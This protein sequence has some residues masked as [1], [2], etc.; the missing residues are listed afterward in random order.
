[1]NLCSLD[2]LLGKKFEEF[3][4]DDQKVICTLLHF[5]SFPVT[6]A[7]LEVVFFGLS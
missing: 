4:F 2:L 3:G 1:M 6:F 7:E 5:S